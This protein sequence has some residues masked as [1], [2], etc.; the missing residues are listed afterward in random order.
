MP[1]FFVCGCRITDCNIV[2]F[3][4]FGGLIFIFMRKVGLKNCVLCFSLIGN[5]ILFALLVFIGCIKTTFVYSKLER[6]GI[7]KLDPAQRGDYWCIRGWTN[8]LEK[9]HINTNVVFFGNSIICGSNFEEYFPNIGICNLG[10]PGDN[11][12]GMLLRVNQIKAVNPE[13]VFVM[14]GINGLYVQTEQ[15]FAKKYTTL[16]DS[17]ISAVPKAKIYLQSI[18]PVNPSM[19][20]GK[21]RNYKA[22]AQRNEIIREIAKQ[23]G[24]IYVDLYN[25][26]AVDGIMPAELTRDGVHLFPESYDRWANE[27]RKYIEE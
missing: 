23:K 21:M 18:L 15:V 26:Y 3:G 19:N 14:A 24:C 4:V 16:V 8:T 7:T 22:I 25:L 5:V 9:L 17:I 27:I 6:L 2:R 11:T 13:K 1:T 20:G 12:D 10:Y